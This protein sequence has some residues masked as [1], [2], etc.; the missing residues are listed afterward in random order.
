MAK[1]VLL[2]ILMLFTSISLIGQQWKE[3]SVLASG[4]IY[5]VG[6]TE[7]GL[8]KITNTYLSEAG[9]SGGSIDNIGVYGNQGGMLPSDNSIDRADD[10]QKIKTYKTDGGLVFYAETATVEKMDS[11][12]IHKSLNIY[13]TKNYIY[14]KVNDSS[15]EI[16][17][18]SDN[19]A[20]PTSLNSVITLQRYEI[21]KYNILSNSDIHQGSGQNWYGDIYSGET[22]RNYISNFDLNDLDIS[23]P[24][25]LEVVFASRAKSSTPLEISLSDLTK[26]EYFSAVSFATSS[27][28]KYATRKKLNLSGVVSTTPSE[29][30]LDYKALSSTSEAWVDYIQILSYK[31][32]NGLK[33]QEIFFT[34]PSLEDISLGNIPFAEVW[35]VSDFR[36]PKVH[37]VNDNTLGFK[38]NAYRR[39]LIGASSY[40]TPGSAQKIDNQNFHELNDIDLVILYPSEFKSAADKLAAHRRSHNNY[41]V[42]TV[43]IK[44]LYNEF[45]SGRTDPTAIRDF[46]RMLYKRETQF[47]YLLLFGDGTYDIRNIKN[48]AV[49]HNKIPAYE[50][51]VSEDG[52]DAF[53]Y[54]DYYALLD[55]DEGRGFIGKVDIA[56]GRIPAL[57]ESAANAVVNKIINYDIN[58]SVYGP[59]RTKIGFSADDED[60]NRHIRDADGIARDVEEE[61]KLFT[62]NKIYFD[63]YQQESTQGGDRYYEASDALNRSMNQGQL[64]FSYLGHGGP[65]GF[66]QE[67]V[68]KKQDIDIWDN[69]N[70]LPL[71]ITATC[72]FAGYD[73][74]TVVSMGEYSLLK[75]EGGV[76]ALLTTVRAVYA[77][78]NERL[79]RSTYFNMFEQNINGNMTFGD[80]IKQGKNEREDHASTDYNELL[81][82]RKFT[83]LGDPSQQLAVPQEK[84]VTTKINGHDPSTYVDTLSALEPVTIEGQITDQNDMTLSNFNGQV[85]ISVYD[86]KNQLRTLGQDPKSSEYDFEVYQTLL[87][88]G[89]VDVVDGTFKTSF[90][91]PKDINYS[92]GLGRIS[93]YAYDG[94][95]TD[96]AGYENGFIIGGTYDSVI[97]DTEGPEISLFIDDRSF[98]DGGETTSSPQ[99]IIDLKDDLG[100]NVTGISIGHDLTAKLNNKTTNVLNEYYTADSQEAGSGTAIY[101]YSGLEVGTHEILVQAW[102]LANNSSTATIT[103]E[104]VEPSESSIKVLDPFPSPTIK[105]IT[106]PFECRLGLYDY[107]ATLQVYDALGR[108][109]L[110]ENYSFI[111]VENKIELDLEEKNIHNGVYYYKIII[112]SN[113]L[114]KSIESKTYKFV[115]I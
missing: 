97:S 39:K 62:Q 19:V 12:A 64:V 8:Y 20:S 57:T 26:T 6:I 55:E 35:D 74:P 4:D 73:D 63:A 1:N 68:L 100:I 49:D 25:D 28:G 32:N 7:T 46:A 91:V 82:I 94:N 69:Y 72:T 59:W 111:N 45:S 2:P 103:F 10:L 84:V 24:I 3:E 30:T 44:K 29:L 38:A 58:K 99:L 47:K 88:N 89:V 85:Y 37:S 5:K 76:I 40:L 16:S 112:T 109:V 81:N 48:L 87:Y 23:K 90:I 56:V 105:M 14:I 66:A 31:Y 18:T 9:I 13:D 42:A 22:T 77:D 70:T 33:N 51:P 11:L 41:N 15:E 106:L 115:K 65:R 104:V 113:Q 107:T 110:K 98:T 96:A 92:Y 79:T 80:I 95:I 83:L 43:D 67:R 114:N 86:K 52:I 71:M 60:F 61:F 17:P 54:D 36:N 108:S 101:N 27:L 75:P 78:D 93:Y 34:D 21:D 53:P 50:T 102:D